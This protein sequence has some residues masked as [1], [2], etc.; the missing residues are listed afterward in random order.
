MHDITD[1]SVFVRRQELATPLLVRPRLPGQLLVKL[2]L[3]Q[4]LVLLYRNF[5]LRHDAQRKFSHQKLISHVRVC[6]LVEVESAYK[7]GA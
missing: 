1:P 3:E 4:P 7:G 2:C 6:K 5:L